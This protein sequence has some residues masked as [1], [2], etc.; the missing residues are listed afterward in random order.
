MCTIK[1]PN[2]A[3]FD[4]DANPNTP[5]VPAPDQPKEG[6]KPPVEKK[7]VEKRSADKEPQKK[8]SA[9]EIKASLQGTWS[10]V[11][12]QANGQDA[13]AQILKAYQITFKGDKI[14][15]PTKDGKTE[16]GTFK[17]DVTKSPFQMDTQ[18]PSDKTPDL[19]IFE[20]KNGELRVCIRESDQSARGRPAVFTSDNGLVLMVFRKKG[21]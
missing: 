20:L 8:P 12:M 4:L 18:M 9:E 1:G 13:P 11:S 5:L 2:P 21:P 10:A 17:L 15:V 3:K 14:T 6:P 19:C 16:E 7:P